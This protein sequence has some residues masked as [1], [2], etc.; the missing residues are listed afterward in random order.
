MMVHMC[1]EINKGATLFLFIK[2]KKRFEIDTNLCYNKTGD[3]YWKDYKK[4]SRKQT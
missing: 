2:C 4:F 1:Q 3:R